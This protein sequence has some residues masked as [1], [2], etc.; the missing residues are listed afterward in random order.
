MVLDG[1][2][3]QEYPVNVSC[4][5]QGSIAGPSLFLLYMSSLPEDL[6]HNI[7]AGDTTV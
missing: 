7:S 1:K 3:L 4:V 2:S 6:I 5:P